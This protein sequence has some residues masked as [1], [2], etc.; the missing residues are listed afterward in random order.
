LSATQLQSQLN[1]LD[2]QLY[3]LNEEVEVKCQ[4]LS[5]EEILEMGEIPLMKE[6]K[7]T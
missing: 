3:I 6:S 7:V 4:S 2:V 1:S 5:V